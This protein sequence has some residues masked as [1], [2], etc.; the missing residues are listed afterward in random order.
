MAVEV[1]K[2]DAAS[3]VPVVELTV[4]EAPRCAAI[5]ELRLANAAEDGIEL[6]IA[7]VE[8]LMRR[9]PPSCRWRVEKNI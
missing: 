1:A 9:W 5:G 2:I 7:D 4:L 8:V 6:G 3:A